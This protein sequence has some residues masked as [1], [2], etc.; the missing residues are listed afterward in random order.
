MRTAARTDTNHKQIIE[1]AR[2]LGIFVWDTHQLK[3]CVDC[4]MVVNGSV[5]FVEIKDGA[6]CKSKKQLT[7]GEGTFKLGLERVKGTH[8]IIEKV[9]QVN[10]I[11]KKTI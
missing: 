8:I 10:E 6:K 7:T 2:S 4:V 5:F 11:F 1:H 3:N 9:Q